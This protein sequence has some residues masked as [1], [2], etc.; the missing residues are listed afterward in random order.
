MP[1]GPQLAICLVLGT[2]LP[3]FLLHR[4]LVSIGWRA[5][6]P[7]AVVGFVLGDLFFNTTFVALIYLGG[8]S[9][10]EIAT[11]QTL[12]GKLFW[13]ALC[14]L[15]GTFRACRAAAQTYYVSLPLCWLSLFLL[16]WASGEHEDADRTSNACANRVVS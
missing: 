7:A 3:T 5:T 2:L 13:C 8:D 11:E 16:R 6:L 1:H 15:Y 9:I 4:F 14:V 10:E 12:F